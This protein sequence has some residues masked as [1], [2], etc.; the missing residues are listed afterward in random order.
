MTPQKPIFIFDL[1]NTLYDEV[2]EYGG[3]IA[4]AVEYFLSTT[5]GQSISI[6]EALLCEQLS[7]AHARIGSDWDDDVWQNV[8]ELAKLNNYEATLKQG[9][10]L[11]RK[12][13]ED[14]TKEKA[15]QSTLNAIAKLKQA[16]ASV[17]VATEATENAAS[18]GIIWLGLDGVL[19]GVYA[20][21]FK[22]PYQKAAKTPIREFPPNPHEPTLSL[23]KPH[24]LII[25]AIILDIAKE[26]GQVPSHIMCDDAFDFALDEEL[27]VRTLKKAIEENKSGDEQKIQAKEVL[28]AIQTRLFIKKGPHQNALNAIKARC[29]YVGDSFFKDGF[30]ARNADVP[31]IFAQYGKT[32]SDED[33]EVH[34][35]GKDW[36]YR[37]TGWDKFLIQLTQEAGK[38]PELSDKIKPY[39][40]CEKSF[41]EFADFLKSGKPHAAA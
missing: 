1:H 33:K 5:K 25:G 9:M 21:P 36:L 16:G 34:N 15:F 20:W 30:L 23:Q 19:N 41:Q 27:D 37:V 29:F 38:L 35:K 24:P 14:L 28:R 4:V 18:D 11:R 26:E 3:A 7:D 22:K 8:G 39:F 12:A 31:F 32:V 2:I 17:Y 10:V 13:S 6:D 40:V